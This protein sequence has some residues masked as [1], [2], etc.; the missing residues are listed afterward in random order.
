MRKGITKY[1][2]IAA[3]AASI[4]TFIIIL[5]KRVRS[6]KS[7]TLFSPCTDGDDKL[8][9]DELKNDVNLTDDSSREYISISLDN[10][11]NTQD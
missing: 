9:G 8:K 5:L 6:T 4:I 11:N 3:S 10:N 1:L 2:I 7:L